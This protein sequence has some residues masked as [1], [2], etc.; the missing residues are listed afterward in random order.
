MRG[1]NRNLRPR[2]PRQLYLNHPPHNPREPEVQGREHRI[3]CSA[4]GLAAPHHLF[5]RRLALVARHVED[6]LALGRGVRPIANRRPANGDDRDLLVR[7]TQLSQV[8][9]NSTAFDTISHNYIR[10]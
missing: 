6:R 7:T 1:S 8:A 3:D 10:M 2:S 5:W 4:R 9:R